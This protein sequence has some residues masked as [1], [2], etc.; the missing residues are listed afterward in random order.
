MLG[1]D[2]LHHQLSSVLNLLVNSAQEL[3]LGVLADVEFLAE[4]LDD[5][6]RNLA[7]VNAE[8][9][10]VLS[11]VELNLEDANWFF[12]LLQSVACDSW[13][14][15]DWLRI[16][17]NWLLGGSAISWLRGC[18]LE[19]A[20]SV[21]GVPCLW[22]RVLLLLSES[23]SWSTLSSGLGGLTYWLNRAWTAHGLWLLASWLVPSWW[24]A[25]GIKL[26]ER[27]WLLLKL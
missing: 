27:C 26:L 3:V 21:S 13:L 4:V 20:A 19:V 11:A 9:L 10:N 15:L 14:A 6:L 22:L 23:V 8:K 5:F 16:A 12:F 18:W 1:L 24:L 2:L 7:L 25:E 17:A